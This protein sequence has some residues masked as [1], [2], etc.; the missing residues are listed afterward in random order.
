M[1]PLS[2]PLKLLG[3]LT[4]QRCPV[5]NAAVLFAFGNLL[6]RCVHSPDSRPLDEYAEKSPLHAGGRHSCGSPTQPLGVD[7]GRFT[8]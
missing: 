1:L 7:H 2:C 6:F 8:F 3:Q 4:P 5:H